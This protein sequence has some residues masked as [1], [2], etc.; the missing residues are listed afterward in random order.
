MSVSS[1]ASSTAYSASPAASGRAAAGGK[2]AALSDAEQRVVS[3][4]KQRDREVRAHELAH[5]AAGAGLVTHGAS[6]SYQSGPDGQRYAVGGEVG[7]DVSKARTPEETI[8]KAQQIQAAALAPADPSGADRQ[9]AARAGQMAMEARMEMASR[10]GGASQS[11]GADA[12]YRAVAVAGSQ[13]GAGSQVD[14]Y[15]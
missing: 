7:I 12:A 9:I 15:A 8:A 14:I 1:I 2:S 13:S 10:S 11:G 4:L 6:Y 5:V 3:Q